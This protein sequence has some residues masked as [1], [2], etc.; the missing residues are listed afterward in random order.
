MRI[1]SNKLVQFSIFSLNPIGSRWLFLPAGTKTHCISGGSTLLQKSHTQCS[2]PMLHISHECTVPC[3]HFVKTSSHTF[4][5]APAPRFMSHRAAYYKASGILCTIYTRMWNVEL[6]NHVID[7]CFRSDFYRA[8][9]CVLLP[10]AYYDVRLLACLSK[11]CKRIGLPHGELG[12][13]LM[14]I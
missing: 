4:Q 11:Y 8:K 14:E 12:L 6:V 7:E 10:H 5:S 9:G 1:C 3:I 13:A 2:K